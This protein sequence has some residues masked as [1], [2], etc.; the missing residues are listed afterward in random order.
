MSVDPLE[1]DLERSAGEGMLPQHPR[2]MDEAPPSI[3]SL[4]ERVVALVREH[5]LAAIGI[6]AAVAFV[7]GRLVRAG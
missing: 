5:P 4:K 2:P 3:S 7:L 6:A 1:L